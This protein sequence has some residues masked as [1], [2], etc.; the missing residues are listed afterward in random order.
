MNLV[1]YL[2]SLISSSHLI[3][4]IHLQDVCEPGLLFHITHLTIPSHPIY[5]SPGSK[6]T[7]SIVSTSHLINSTQPLHPSPE[8][9]WTWSII[10]RSLLW[11]SNH[12]FFIHLQHVCELGLLFRISHLIIQSHPLS[13][14]PESM[15]TSSIFKKITHLIIL[16]H[17]FQS[18]PESTWTS[19]IFIRISYLIIPSHTFHPSPGSTWTWSNVLRISHLIISS[20][21]LHL[22]PEGTWNWL[23]VSGSF[24][25]SS[26]FIVSIYLQNV[27]E[28]GRLFQDLSSYHPP[29]LFICPQPEE[30]CELGL[31]F[32]YKISH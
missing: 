31:L 32:F 3:L 15:W 8:S 16:S 13:S 21:S 4:F 7:W 2:R 1:Y 10:L 6:W 12:I 28:I 17:P 23:I 19:L 5:L 29:I 22:S 20:H 14:S 30:V 24:I 11:L 18:S 9:T 26:H 25:W 27:R